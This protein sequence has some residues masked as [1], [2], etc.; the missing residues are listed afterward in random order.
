MSMNREEAEE[1]GTQAA[2]GAVLRLL[3]EENEG[4]NRSEGGLGQKGQEGEE[5]ASASHQIEKEKLVKQIA[6][7]EEKVSKLKEKLKRR[8]RE[9][10][11]LSEPPAQNDHLTESEA[12]TFLKKR[13]ETSDDDEDLND[14]SPEGENLSIVPVGDTS[15][16]EPPS[17]SGRKKQ[18]AVDVLYASRAELVAEVVWLR[19]EHGRLRN[20]LRLSAERLNRSKQ[21][22][23][24][25]KRSLE[26]QLRDQA[27]IAEAAGSLEA[28]RKKI[29]DS[30]N[31]AAKWKTRLTAMEVERDLANRMKE[32]AELRLRESVMRSETEKVERAAAS[33]LTERKLEEAEARIADLQSALELAKDEG[34]GEGLRL[35]IRNL[36]QDLTQEKHKLRA[37]E[38][39]AEQSRQTMLALQKRTMALQQNLEREETE[40][41]EGA[42]AVMQK[43]DV[44]TRTK[45]LKQAELSP[46]ATQTDPS[47]TNTG[48]LL[49]SPGGQEGTRKSAD[50]GVG[51]A[52]SSSSATS[53]VGE[54][55][56]VD[57]NSSAAV[58]QD[59]AAR[60]QKAER[61]LTERNRQVVVMGAQVES[62]KTRAAEQQLQLENELFKARQ[63]IEM[64]RSEGS[65]LLAKKKKKLKEAIENERRK[66]RKDIDATLQAE[67]ERAERENREVIDS[68]TFYL[69]LR[70]PAYSPDRE[71]T[72]LHYLSSFLQTSVSRLRVI[73][74][75]DLHEDTPLDEIVDS[76]QEMS[77]HA[78]QKQQSAYRAFNTTQTA[79]IMQME[80]Q[81]DVKEAVE[82]ETGE[83]EGEDKK[84]RPAT[85]NSQGT[86][87]PGRLRPTAED[88]EKE[89]VSPAPLR[90][91]QAQP[92]PQAEEELGAE[93]GPP[94]EKGHQTVSGGAM[95]V[96]GSAALSRPASTGTGRYKNT[97][98]SLYPGL[99]STKAVLS[100]QGPF[101]PAATVTKDQLGSM[102]L[103][104]LMV[105][106]SEDPQTLSDPKQNSA[107]LVNKLG[108][109]IQRGSSLLED[110]GVCAMTILRGAGHVKVRWPADRCRLMD[111]RGLQLGGRYL[112]VS[113]YKLSDP[114]AVR[115]LASDSL[116]GQDWLVHLMESDVAR[117]V[118]QKS[119]L[120]RDYLLEKN[121]V[122]AVRSSL[123]LVSRE[124]EELLC[125]VEH[126]I[127]PPSV[128]NDRA[129]AA[130]TFAALQET[131]RRSRLAPM[132]RGDLALS[133]ASHSND[134]NL[135]TV[136]T[137]SNVPTDALATL[138]HAA[139]TTGFL[140]AAEGPRLM[141]VPDLGL[142]PAA[143]DDAYSQRTQVLD[144]LLET[145][146]A[147]Y[148]PRTA[149]KL[150]DAAAGAPPQL[151]YGE[152]LGT[153]VKSVRFFE[154][155]VR[156]GRDDDGDG[157]G[158]AHF[159]YLTG[160]CE[161]KT[162]EEEGV[163][164]RFCLAQ[165][166][167]C[168]NLEVVISNAPSSGGS[169][170]HAESREFKDGLMALLLVDEI[171]YPPSF[172]MRVTEMKQNETSWRSPGFAVVIPKPDVLQ[173]AQTGTLSLVSP[174]PLAQAGAIKLGNRARLLAF[175]HTDAL[176]AT[177]KVVQRP[178]GLLTTDPSGRLG[179]SSQ[180]PLASLSA[181]LEAQGR[182]GDGD[183]FE[184]GE[185]GRMT[186]SI[187]TGTALGK[188]GSAE[189][190]LL[191]EDRSE[192]VW[193]NEET[194]RQRERA[195]ET[196]H[197]RLIQEVLGDAA[198]TQKPLCRVSRK[199]TFED[200]T[201]LY[202][203][204]A[205]ERQEPFY[206]LVLVAQEAG[207]DRSFPLL[208][209]ATRIFQ[210]SACE[211]QPIPGMNAANSHAI[212][213]Q[214]EKQRASTALLLADAAEFQS[215]RGVQNL[216]LPSATA[217]PPPLRSTGVIPGTS[218]GPHIPRLHYQTTAG[219]GLISGGPERRALQA[220][221]QAEALEWWSSGDR[222]G[223]EIFSGEIEL[224]VEA[225]T[226]KWIVADR[227]RASG[228]HKQEETDGNEDVKDPDIIR[229]Q[230]R[231]FHEAQAAD[232]AVC[233]HNFMVIARDPDYVSTPS[234]EGGDT[235]EEAKRHAAGFYS[236]RL[237]DRILSHVL[238]P[239]DH[240]LLD[241]AHKD[242]L[243]QR[244]VDSLDLQEASHLTKRPP[245]AD[246]V[247]STSRAGILAL[248]PPPE[249]G[250]RFTPD[251]LVL[252]LRSLPRSLLR[253]GKKDIRGDA[254]VSELNAE[255]TI[256]VPPVGGI[257]TDLTTLPKRP[258]GP[259]AGWKK[260]A[261]TLRT[262]TG[263]PIAFFLDSEG[264]GLWHRFGLYDPTASLELVREQPDPWGAGRSQWTA[265]IPTSD[266]PQP[267]KVY[268]E[269]RKMRGQA[270]VLGLSEHAFP[271]MVVGM[272]WAVETGEDVRVAVRDD[273]VNGMVPRSVR[274]KLA[275]IVE[276]QLRFGTVS[277]N[278]TPGEA[279]NRLFDMSGT[280]KDTLK[281]DA[282]GTAPKIPVVSCLFRPTDFQASG[283]QLLY[284]GSRTLTVSAG[285]GGSP[286]LSNTALRPL[287]GTEEGGV[288]VVTDPS[289]RKQ[290]YQVN[291]SV[292]K[293]QYCS[294]FTLAI[295][296]TPENGDGKLH[297]LTLSD[298]TTPKPLSVY[299]E[300]RNICGLQLLV[301][302]VEDSDP[303]CL[304]LCV[305]HPRTG[306]L[307]QLIVRDG[308]PG[309]DNST[310]PGSAVLT[311][312]DEKTAG[313]AGA[314]LIFPRATD[315]PGRRQELLAFF[316]QKF[317]PHAAASAGGSPTL[318]A[319]GE[320]DMTKSTWN[321]PESPSQLRHTSALT[322][323]A[324][325]G[326][327]TGF[328][329][330][331]RTLLSSTDG[332]VTEGGT[333][334]R[335]KEREKGVPAS[336]T[337][338]P[339]AER[340]FRCTQRLYN[341]KPVVISLVR[342][343]APGAIPPSRFKLM[344]FNPQLHREFV[345]HLPPPLLDRLM[346]AFALPPLSELLQ[347]RAFGSSKGF[348]AEG[349]ETPED[350]TPEQ[351][352]LR[353]NFIRVV[354]GHVYV[355]PEGNALELRA[356]VDLPSLSAE[357]QSTSAKGIKTGPVSPT[358]G[359][360]G[361]VG[362]APGRLRFAHRID[363]Q[364]GD[365]QPDAMSPSARHQ[366]LQSEKE[367][368]KEKEKR[369]DPG[370]LVVAKEKE[371]PLDHLNKIRVEVFEGTEPEDLLTFNLNLRI[372]ISQV[373]PG[374]DLRI[375]GVFD[376][377]ESSPLLEEW[378]FRSRAPYLL[379]ACRE[380]D[381][382][383]AILDH[384]YTYR[385]SHDLAEVE[386]GR[387]VASTDF[388]GG[389]S[390]GAGGSESLPERSVKL[391]FV[392]I[393]QSAGATVEDLDALPGYM[394]PDDAGVGMEA[395]RR[396]AP[397]G[398]AGTPLLGLGEE[399]EDSD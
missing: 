207:T 179:E 202:T 349:G 282:T 271:H 172:L 79:K 68:G 208:V 314:P 376:L 99:G 226:K 141:G 246:S 254:L 66:M 183:I 184:V 363:F 52:P 157:E 31:E 339:K 281:G 318:V 5:H 71:P 316:L 259:G 225:E 324:R 197:G 41:V 227:L 100:S 388:Q 166:G 56:L 385:H 335:E 346:E 96:A 44:P 46:R 58:L 13:P 371:D 381:L 356:S 266:D 216:V 165:Q 357:R 210:L 274:D 204:T 7:L 332:F 279:G 124:G 219:L 235:D 80:N 117:L 67:R 138:A 72:L 25:D 14:A 147:P 354:M 75:V 364:G 1:I 131:I 250:A 234:T 389:E 33:R 173:F 241:I 212:G 313:M 3:K 231:I 285:G 130:D 61:E 163:D 51:G 77:L 303:R 21:R 362:G 144:E 395:E 245:S 120:L 132:P 217:P 360:K 251:G 27:L 19:A 221:P 233:V 297:L 358:G 195:R 351:K 198:R 307:W 397:L 214:D 305:S 331:T 218:Q 64:I 302:A 355:K 121:L 177:T 6:L 89:A 171:P 82:E 98:T 54:N 387:P 191:G 140:K 353:E 229:L 328:P 292:T 134:Q 264:G 90:G 325:G 76:F 69:T 135:K 152:S 330:G 326:P 111:K 383:E 224:D 347:S 393:S 238:P 340:L 367:A 232:A 211:P 228:R 169:R 298:K 308:Q 110:L 252:V 190:L 2:E 194:V 299:A 345:L 257:L 84:E 158:E 162:G 151:T 38:A 161:Q 160:T 258:A 199:M 267:F 11:L 15:K 255:E 294:E 382:I 43:F 222:Q 220:L 272:A 378:L 270:C 53:P 247:S 289:R 188:A 81:K 105:E 280:T 260:V 189:A 35:Q 327:R 262:F 333:A 304:R 278:A 295:E 392:E 74:S 263:V 291:V 155:L 123:R 379:S 42:A 181:A 116:T 275:E 320:M 55:T 10:A 276:Q 126:S 119:K 192:A 115:V 24:E 94:S 20:D 86:E 154:H 344:M 323:G 59:L 236:L 334:E 352:T 178:E 237:N 261:R 95:S 87:V 29:L 396:G 113:A 249:A 337:A 187:S 200:Q 12:F 39:Q 122:E 287:S 293:K 36:Q 47:G 206:H 368:E 373:L 201:S 186:V 49:R 283:S 242:A 106:I 253:S 369:C 83:G 193:L 301:A 168:K 290:K 348:T 125:A 18:P 4:V 9:V 317:A 88:A 108:K 146:T 156:L 230:V 145:A 239:V 114:F 306:F 365:A 32:A 398:G 265:S 167:S 361:L 142:A 248:T 182:R 185:G 37:A 203:V 391:G 97:A 240:D 30:T 22:S 284:S 374:G 390:G 336:E 377:H 104:R 62:V 16:A 384:A 399:G 63:E 338:G 209:D 394:R 277:S 118:G 150:M 26:S 215:V 153:G 50:V 244:I 40:T 8:T 57:P 93:P 350:L 127:A 73:E 34:G 286:P 101:S 164:F 343:E 296:V 322:A 174:V 380:G 107:V 315:P 60:A 170:L 148:S 309:A 175:A 243:I 28:M 129:V 273:A 23:E 128:L 223:A 288:P 17:P 102:P 359:A 149:S 112:V 92:E 372:R 196:V 311:T 205:Y 268:V 139:H 133:P 341:G 70:T 143:F 48:G 213:Q 269:H 300:V 45:T 137:F 103:I 375:Q 329:M 91:S 136:G 342:E 321:R 180:Q 366:Q 85:A 176:E 159:F 370:A 78:L 256:S 109:D 65:R 312:K 310:I 386:G 319:S